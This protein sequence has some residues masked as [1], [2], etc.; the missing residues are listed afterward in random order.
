MDFNVSQ[1]QAIEFDK[2]ICLVLAGPGSGKTAVLTHRIA[3][4]INERKVKSSRILVIT[5]TKAAALEM[6]HRFHA[7]SSNTGSAVTFGTFHAVFFTILKHAY[8]YS[9]GNI[10]KS[11]NQYNFVRNEMNML[12]LEYDDEKE[13]VGR[14]LAEISKV[15]S[16]GIGIDEYE[17]VSCPCQSFR[18]IY[19]NYDNMLIKR[20][21]IDFDDMIVQ[22]L[23]LLTKRED[24][25]RAWQEKYEYILIDEFQDINKAQ[26]DVIR[27]L[28][29][30]HGNL[31]VVGDDDQSIYGFRGSKPD[32][33]L[34]FKDYYPDAE[35]IQLGINYRCSGNIIMA[36]Q[37][38]IEENKLRYFKDIR[39]NEAEGEKVELHE[40]DSLEDEKEFLV[41]EIKRLNCEGIDYG[42]IAVLNRTNL[43]N[44]T[45]F[46]RIQNEGMP[47]TGGAESK[48]LYEHWIAKDIITYLRIATGCRE[49]EEFMRIL[50]KPVRYIKRGY[51][52]NPVSFDK[53]REA[54]ASD[55]YMKKVISGFEWDL[56]ILQKM[57][58]F[59]AVN[60]IRKRIG[61]DDYLSDYVC[62]KKINKE[63][64]EAVIDELT[65]EAKKYPSIRMW[66]EAI[67]RKEREKE[68]EKGNA[69]DILKNNEK[70][71][72]VNFMT[73]HSSKGLEFKVVFVCDVCEG[74]IPYN[75]AVLDE[76][77]EE[78]RRMFYVAMTRAKEK[79]YLLYPKH[80]YNKD[81][82]K[83][84]FIE[85]LEATPHPLLHIN[86]H[87][88]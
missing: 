30:K 52:S 6:K 53:L 83:S 9:A 41:N 17:A 3:Y 65:C 57:G 58:A 76:E 50:N 24:Y 88:P 63:E 5:F 39:A 62:E 20:G 66:L 60:Y 16:E 21:L 46:L 12:E 8:N 81:T 25:R 54:Y 68:R 45:F 78:E 13:A 36:A 33:M 61:Y 87:T 7:L 55:E 64:L 23:E 26:F 67:T 44:E 4:L 29:A 15:K 11:E 48:D 19:K 10:I 72:G 59:A 47:C 82:T 77:I 38:V 80:R 1:K 14:V 27:V 69:G 79:L 74:V 40:F 28:A 85:E 35:M 70:S 31:F 2:G 42:D 18:R 71:G 32:I 51:L 22:C 75:R 86:L 73:M 43:I 37:K 56:G 34:H 49:R 84:R